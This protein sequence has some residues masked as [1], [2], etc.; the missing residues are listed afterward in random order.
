MSAVER[1]LS[2]P[3]G[4]TPGPGF[5][6]SAGPAVEVATPPAPAPGVLPARLLRRRPD[7][8]RL[9]EEE[10]EERG[11]RYVPESRL[12]GEVPYE[13]GNGNEADGAESDAAHPAVLREEPGSGR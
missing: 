8:V 7:C 3:T 12:R 2:G 10:D 11:V 13:R 6:A 5:G 9:R 4:P 1:A